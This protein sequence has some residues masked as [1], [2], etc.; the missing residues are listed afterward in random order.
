MI[1]IKKKKRNWVK[2]ARVCGGRV[3]G[4]GRESSGWGVRRCGGLWATVAFGRKA[5]T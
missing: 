4:L 1:K 5:K 2:E 3:G